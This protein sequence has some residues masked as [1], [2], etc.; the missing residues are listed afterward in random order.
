MRSALIILLA[1]AVAIIAF[2]PQTINALVSAHNAIY[3]TIGLQD[4][5]FILQLRG[6]ASPTPTAAL[7]LFPSPTSNNPALH[8]GN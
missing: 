5:Q 1:L 4:K 6:E 2:L 7:Q 8:L 3:A